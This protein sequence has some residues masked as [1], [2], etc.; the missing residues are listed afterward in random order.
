M[1]ETAT[2]QPGPWQL[3]GVGLGPGDPELVTWKGVQAIRQ[4]RLVFVPRSQDGER[5]LALRIAEPWL[6]R[7]R[8]RIVEL[9]L[10][11][12]RDPARLIPAWQAAADRIAQAFQELSP[13]QGP[14]LEALQGVYLLLGDPLL[15][16]TFTPIRQELARRH[17]AIQ[18]TVIPGVTSFAA[19]AAKA[20]WPLATT[21]DR[22]A[23]LPASYETDAQALG[24]LLQD[25]DTVILMKVGPVL[26]RLLAALEELGLLDRAFY[27]ERVGMPEERLV[28]DLHSLPPEP[29]PYLSLLIVGKGRD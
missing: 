4:A 20:Q 27:A 17:P 8:Q 26:P 22:V 11:M 10:P 5:S 19:A 1:T 18:V 24:R 13:G 15:Y 6:D 29:A 12:T 16:G 2:G 3:T 23:I 7:A 21:S 14:R 9:P 28:L 25:F